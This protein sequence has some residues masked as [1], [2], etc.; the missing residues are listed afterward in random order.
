MQRIFSDSLKRKCYFFERKMEIL[1]GPYTG[2][3]N[4][5]AFAKFPFELDTFQKHAVCSIDEDRNVLVTA[6]T[7]SGKTL[8]AEYATMRSL[9]RGKRIIYTS[10][11]KSLSNQKFYEFKQKFP[12]ASVGIFTGDIKFNPFSNV[13]IMTTEILRNMLYRMR[14][15]DAANTREGDITIDLENEVDIVV[16]D[17]IHYINDKDRGKVWEECII[18]LPKNVQLIM[19]SAT[20]DRADEFASW[21]HRVRERPIDLIPTF[22]RYVPLKHYYYLHGASKDGETALDEI[23][24]KLM[25]LLDTDGKFQ[26]TNFEKLIRVKRNYDKY[27]GKR[28]YGQTG[29]LNPLVTFLMERDL[30]PA[31]FF[32]FSRKKCEQYAAA[33]TRSLI[34]GEEQAQVEKIITQQLLKIRGHEKYS[35]L[36]QF[37]MLKRMLL[38]GVSVHHSGLIPIFK[39]LIELLFAQKLVKVLFAT[40]T[41]AVGVNMPTKT[42]LYTELSKRDNNG[43]RMLMTN[44]YTQMSGRAGR[45]GIDTVGHVILLPNLFQEVPTVLEMERM[46]LGKSQRIQSKFTL[47]YLFVLKSTNGQ[48]AQSSLLSQELEQHIS[49]IIAQLDE[50]NASQPAQ[51]SFEDFCDYEELKNQSEFFKLS[52]KAEKQRSE[53]IAKMESSP[54]FQAYKDAADWKNKHTALQEELFY[55]QTFIEYYMEKV[56]QILMDNGYMDLE[57]KPTLKGVVASRVSECNPILLTEMLVEGMFDQ[58][59]APEIAATLSIF[60]SDSKSESIN[61]SSLNIPSRVKATIQ[62]L[63]PICEKYLDLETQYELYLNSNW[64]LS[65]SMTESAYCWAKQEPLPSDESI[66]E[67]D[68]VKAMLKLVS[69]CQTLATIAEL[70]KKNELVSHLKGLEVVIMRDIVSVESLYIL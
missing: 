35:N 56:S 58:L 60:L 49:G 63:Q 15:P 18:M 5:P 33:V 14:E 17:E 54:S 42:V 16:F 4:Y 11:I 21:V 34:T 39:E 8:V 10:P 19:L 22:K 12:E 29:M 6:F 48:I 46:M 25:P 7:G 36:P 67:G 68:F 55:N 61:L 57:H 66:F 44:E 70:L 50:L 24:H 31:L 52:R 2:D 45:R 40:E 69:L 28:N 59:T 32:V 13:T 43:Y 30:C 20:I 37:L 51:N 64:D 62:K 41:F 3:P 9:E 38:K 23:S 47:D 65:L 1:S 27:V 26:V 53:R